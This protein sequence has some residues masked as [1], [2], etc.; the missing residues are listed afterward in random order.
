VD[1]V[2]LSDVTDK[3]QGT[4]AR[5]NDRVHGR[6]LRLQQY[7]EPTPVWIVVIRFETI[8]RNGMERPVALKSLDDGYRSDRSI[9]MRGAAPLAAYQKP[10][11]AGVFVF[12][13]HGNMVL[14][15]KFHS[16]WETR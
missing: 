1:G 8:E 5:A 11:G 2:L 10:P 3:K 16:E 13:E 12:A 6:I 14:D 4:M 9:R 7:M 15:Q